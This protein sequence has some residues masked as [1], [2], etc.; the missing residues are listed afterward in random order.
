G[1][2]GV[3]QRLGGWRLGQLLEAEAAQAHAEAAELD[4]NVRAGGER[5]DGCGPA[6]KYLFVLAGIGADSDRAAHV[7]ER[8]LCLRDGARAV[9]NLVDLGMVEPGVEGEA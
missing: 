8:N 3:C 7:I 1:T 4:V 5:L 6:R 2:P 9:A